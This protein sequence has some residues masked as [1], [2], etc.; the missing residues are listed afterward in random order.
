M[1]ERVVPKNIESRM[2]DGHIGYARIR[3]FVDGGIAEAL[4][5]ALAALDA[6]GATSY[7]IDMRGNPGG[8]LDTPAISLFVKDGV[9]VRDRGPR[10]ASS[11]RSPRPATRCRRCR[12]RCCWRT[13][14]RARWRRS[15]RRRCR[16]TARRT[17][18]ARTTNGC[19][20]FTDVAA[21]G[22]RLIAGRDDAREPR[23]GERPR[24]ERRGRG[25]G[26]GGGA[27]AG[28][29]RQRPRPAAR[30][31]GRALLRAGTVHLARRELRLTS[32]P[33]AP[34]SSRRRGR[35]RCARRRRR[36]RC[37]RSSRTSGAPP[38]RAGR[39]SPSRRARGTA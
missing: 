2:I 39:S 10:R 18:S 3:N 25:A 13:T 11:R 16:S 26:P 33:C 27:H 24:T 31:G 7:I 8:R 37:R 14:A 9:V 17:S 4:R 32:A 22:R 38:T 19:V 15:S 6:Q 20:G 36:R 5:E 12:R 23:A 21:A 1:R 29:H 28:R 30:R 35:R 34:R